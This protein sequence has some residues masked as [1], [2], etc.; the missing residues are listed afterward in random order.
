MVCHENTI[1]VVYGLIVARM[2][3][4]CYAARCQRC[5]GL[6]TYDG[7]MIEHP[8]TEA[9]ASTTPSRSLGRPTMAD[10][11]REVGVSAK[12]VSRVVNGDSHVSPET[13]AAITE[14]IER[15]GFRRNE[16]ARLL[17]QGTA[18][19][20]GLLIED[21]SDPFYSSLTRAVEE[22][23][24][25]YEHVLFVASSDEDPRRAERLVTSFI[26]RGVDGLI[27]A[28]AEGIDTAM[29]RDQITRKTPIV[30][31]DR[32]IVGMDIDTVLVDNR[33]GAVAA[34]TH[35]IDGG[36]RRIAFFGD[37]EAV[38][39]ARER[40]D[41]YL[42]ALRQAGI[43]P[44]SALIRMAAPNS[45][46]AEAALDEQARLASPPTAIL[47]GNNRW[48]IQLL[49]ISANRSDRPAFIGFDDFELADVLRP[50]I[51]VVAQD[52]AAMGRVAAE[53]LFRRIQAN[54]GPTQRVQL[55]TTLI[56]RGS[57]ELPGPFLL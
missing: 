39:T 17:R 5:H 16:S 21:I 29:L 26:S 47:A 12:T 31:V 14:A 56:A 11:A 13:L 8:S 23:V 37:D 49:R 18:S 40:R 53:Q 15:L 38:F 10:V 19:T 43:E 54:S 57:G 33:G 55:S 52:P 44:D 24:L 2:G 51:S 20:I 45:A 34:T 1:H 25:G 36:H 42:D 6:F 46:G 27:I 35:L 32:P 30:L 22:C 4:R 28:P 41:G 50:G 9:A 7:A 48:S 3:Y